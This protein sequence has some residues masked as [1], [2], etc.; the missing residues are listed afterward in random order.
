VALEIIPN[1]LYWISSDTPPKSWSTAFY[2]NIDQDLV[3]EPYFADFGPL[4]IGKIHLFCKELDR[5]LAG[6]SSKECKIYHHTS[7]SFDQQANAALL[8]GAF[9]VIS[10]K[11]SAD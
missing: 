8:M 7:R 5:L 1:K 4:D 2:F 9:M 6:S 11:F 10:L 3:Y